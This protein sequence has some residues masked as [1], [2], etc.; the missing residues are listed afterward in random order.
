M[1]GR[2]HRKHTLL[3]LVRYTETELVIHDSKYDT[4]YRL[5]SSDISDRSERVRYGTWKLG[6][7]RV[8][9]DRFES[10]AG[11]VRAQF[12]VQM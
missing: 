11:I 9:H 12:C 4:R 2:R 3:V 8:I 10:V 5:S 1:S 7:L 6:Y